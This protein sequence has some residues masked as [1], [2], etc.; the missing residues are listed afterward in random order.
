MQPTSSRLE[1]KVALITGSGR[2]MGRAH[3]ELLATNGADVV[4]H[5]ISETGAEET[6]E[7]VRRQ[8]R[9]ALVAVADVADISAMKDVVANAEARLGSVDILINNAGIGADRATIEQIDEAMFDR[10]FNIHVKG[11]FFT[12]R[13][14]VPGMK[15]RR[16]GAII[17]VSSIWGMVGHHFG[18][19]Y[20]GAK[21]TLLGFTKS[22]AKEL[23]PYRIT[24][25]AVAP[26][27]VAT[28]M[29]IEKDGI[30]A[31]RERMARVPLGRW[32]EPSE[33][34][35]GVLYL[36]TAGFVTGQ[37]LCISGGET[38]VGI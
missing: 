35:D 27:G 11:T 6:A 37:V 17:N 19:T 12:T 25:N 38:I 7:L 23:A 13:A 10:I 4:V 2:G 32:A 21:A 33:V 22:W 1:G 18:S 24:V 34:S 28:P 15:A 26:G 30:D 20:C 14:V 36:V 5:D 3:A 9:R 31:V 8:G 16:S 29:A